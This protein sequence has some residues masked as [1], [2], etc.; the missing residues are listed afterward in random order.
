MSVEGNGITALGLVKSSRVYY[1]TQNR[2]FGSWSEYQIIASGSDGRSA[3]SGAVTAYGTGG[4]GGSTDPFATKDADMA[5]I[6]GNGTNTLLFPQSLGNTKGDPYAPSEA[7]IN[8]QYSENLI[9]IIKNK[10][11]GS[12][13]SCSDL[14]ENRRALRCLSGDQS[15]GNG[16][17]DIEDMDTIV[18]YSNGKITI[19]EDLAIPSTSKQLIIIAKSI[20]IESDVNEVNAWLIV[21][22]GEFNTCA[23]HIIDQPNHPEN[24]NSHGN[25][26]LLQ[27]CYNNLLINGPVILKTGSTS[28][29]NPVQLPRTFGGGSKPDGDSFVRAPET[30]VQRAE[31]F[32]YDPEIVEWAY[33]ES[34]KEPQ[35][36]T[37]YTES[38]TPRL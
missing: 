32:N 10:Y 26:E 5:S 3:S 33:N 31:V 29:Y 38:L 2:I 19:T 36:V 12:S 34:R 8:W 15:L 24:S 18:V 37:T 25:M 22:G 27:E 17:V 1:G 21:D 16:L 28:G 6:S 35:I 23:G 14:T 20:E 7:Q 4:I 30:Y 9:G 13:G 11:V